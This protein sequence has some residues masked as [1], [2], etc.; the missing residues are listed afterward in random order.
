MNGSE[1][2]PRH[3]TV[4][5]T[6][7]SSGIGQQTCRVLAAAGDHVHAV[8]RRADRLAELERLGVVPHP[9]DLTN[10]EQVIQL[11]RELPELDA[12]IH[13]AGGARGS[14][15]VVES[16]TEDWQWMWSTNV[17]GTMFL[18]RQLVPRLI[19]QG[20][21]HV[22]VVTSVASFEALDNSAG[23]STSKHAQSALTQTLRSE[24]LNTTVHVTEIAPGLVDTEFFQQRF[25][26]DL[27][28]AQ[29]VFT[30]IAPLTPIDIAH[31]IQ[32]AIDQPD[33]VNIDRIVLRPNAQGSYGRFHRS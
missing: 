22:V 27:T 11:G 8:A 13:C 26:G 30:G 5:V 15:P 25:P 2:R 7:A 28:R 20:H 12:V 33:H 4:L 3:R 23:Y 1:E 29:Q 9:T 16:T 21:G 32:Y 19:A 14:A 17:M 6:G 24:L 18:L 31:A 10:E